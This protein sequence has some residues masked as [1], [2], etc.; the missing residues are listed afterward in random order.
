LHARCVD[1]ALNCCHTASTPSSYTLDGSE[2]G[3]P[4][5]GTL[6]L[7][8]GVNYLTGPGINN[9]DLSLQEQFA[10]RSASPDTI[11]NW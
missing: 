5:V 7:E 4:Q 6:G 2:F 3:L 10:E 8:S 1:T 9:W 11:N